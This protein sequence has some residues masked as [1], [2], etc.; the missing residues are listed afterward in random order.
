MGERALALGLAG[1]LLA[2][3]ATA[4]HA[5]ERWPTFD[6]SIDGS[7]PLNYSDD[8]IRNPNGGRADL[9]S[10]YFKLSLNGRAVPDLHYAFYASIGVDK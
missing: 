6:L 3:A 10:P 5:A 1:F 8:R 2:A 9:T 4:S 7:V